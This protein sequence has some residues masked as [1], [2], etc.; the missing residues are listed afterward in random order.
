MFNGYGVN[1]YGFIVHSCG[2]V[3]N[4]HN[5]NT[6]FGTFS[7]QLNMGVCANLIKEH[8]KPDKRNLYTVITHENYASPC[9]I[10]DIDNLVKLYEDHMRMEE[11]VSAL[12]N[13]EMHEEHKELALNV[14]RNRFDTIKYS[15][16]NIYRI[17]EGLI[18]Q[19]IRNRIFKPSFYKRLK[20]VL[21]DLDKMFKTQENRMA[22]FAD[23]I[24]RT[25]EE[26]KNIKNI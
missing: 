16:Y 5:G 4:S 13:C 20:V 24:N 10:T 14:L 2:Y 17:R 1:E 15:L 6:P 19:L 18:K 7:P 9:I 12:E 22:E 3:P 25:L 23:L 11:S 26:R 8:I 21:K